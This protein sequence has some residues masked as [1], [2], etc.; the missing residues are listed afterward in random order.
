MDPGLM[1]SACPGM[2]AGL[3]RRCE[4]GRRGLEKLVQRRDRL[5][6]AAVLDVVDEAHQRVDR[7]RRYAF[8]ARERADDADLRVDLG[9]A[10]AHREIAPDAAVGLGVGAVE[11]LHGA[12]RVERL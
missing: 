6:P 3:R 1:P 2:T 7:R 4:L 5:R 12:D 8:F 10:L 9:L 11:G